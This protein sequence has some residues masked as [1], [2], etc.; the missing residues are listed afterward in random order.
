MGFRQRMVQALYDAVL[1]RLVT[2][3]I[4]AQVLARHGAAEVEP[5][6]REVGGELAS[7]QIGR[8]AEG[9]LDDRLQVAK[10]IWSELGGLAD[11]RCEG[12]RCELEEL[13]CPFADMVRRFPEV[14]QLA[15]AL[16]QRLLDSAVVYEHIM[17][18]AE[19]RCLFRV[20]PS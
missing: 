12:P 18:D 20:A 2:L 9:T 3:L 10:Q 16:L 17:R 6:L 11:V 14:C 13:S 7:D 5:I 19:P 15:Q 4:P 1:G 8:V